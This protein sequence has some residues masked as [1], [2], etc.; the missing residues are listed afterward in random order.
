MK[1]IIW[2]ACVLATGC[3]TEAPKK[4]VPAA[5]ST[6]VVAATTGDTMTNKPAVPTTPAAATIQCFEEKVGKD[7]TTVA[8]KIAADSTVTGTYD[9]VPFQ[10][11]GGRGTLKG[12]LAKDST[13]TADWD[14]VIEGSNQVEQVVLKVE[15]DA[16]KQK[17]GELTETNLGSKKVRMVLKNPAKAKFSKTF[18]KIDCKK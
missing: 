6:P 17:Q 8:L 3:Q 9:W 7:V 13:I 18:K 16:L 15:K 14:Y 1:K 2:I 5:T 4:E 12:K 10:K 11:D